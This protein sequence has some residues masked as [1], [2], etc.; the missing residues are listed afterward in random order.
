M[1]CITVG[2]ILW[3]LIQ[4]WARAAQ[5]LA[6]TQ[7]E[8]SVVAFFACAIGMFIVNWQKPKDEFDEHEADNRS[9][10]II[11][12]LV[13]VVESVIKDFK[14]N[15][16]KF[17]HRISN[18]ISKTG[19]LLSE[20]SLII[21][22]VL[23]GAIHLIAWNFEFPT[24]IERDL[25]W[26]AALWCTCI[27]PILLFGYYLSKG[28]LWVIELLDDHLSKHNIRFFDDSPRESSN[29]RPQSSRD[30]ITAQTN[31]VCEGQATID[32]DGI[33]AT[34]DG[35]SNNASDA[36]IEGGAATQAKPCLYVIKLF[37]TVVEGVM[38]TLSLL[39]FLV[40]VIFCVLYVAARLCILVEMFRTLCFLPPEAYVGTWAA[41]L[42][43]LD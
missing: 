24:K 17:G 43:G 14:G 21:G 28:L 30:S 33:S 5:H 37:V 16:S 20:V 13:S 36:D 40:F 29:T 39:G 34:R 2:Q 6:V 38:I 35:S 41:N 31:E 32:Q 7:L 3:V 4:I 10:G 1:R 9:R 12:R 15:D 22:S 27:V 19:R 25:W 42:P 23:F 18:G 8:V 26:A 11:T